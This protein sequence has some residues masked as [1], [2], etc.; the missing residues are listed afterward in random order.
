MWYVGACSYWAPPVTEYMYGQVCTVT[1]R[2]IPTRGDKK[3]G[4]SIGGKCWAHGTVNPASPC[5]ICDVVANPHGWSLNPVGVNAIPGFTGKML[6]GSVCDDGA[7][8]THTDICVRDAAYAHPVSGTPHRCKGTPYTCPKVVADRSLLNCYT[9]STCRGD[10]TCDTVVKPAGVECFNNATADACMPVWTCD[11]KLAACPTKERWTPVIVPGHARRLAVDNTTS[12]WRYPELAAALPLADEG[13]PYPSGVAVAAGNWS[14]RCGALVVDAGYYVTDAGD[15]AATCYPSRVA[16]WASTTPP[17]N[18]SVRLVAF[19]NATTGAPAPLPDGTL[20][21][22]VVRGTNIDGGRSYKCSPRFIVDASPPTLG[23]VTNLHP[24]LGTPLPG[25]PAYH[26]GTALRFTV[27][28]FA[29]PHSSWSGFLKYEYMVAA[30]PLNASLPSYWVTPVA[31]SIGQAQTATTANVLP[32][33]ATATRYVVFVRAW[34]SAALKSAWVEGASVVI[35]RTGPLRLANVTDGAYV[36]SVE[37]PLS[38]SWAGSFADPE[39]GISHYIVFWGKSRGSNDLIN[40]TRYE[41]GVTSLVVPFPFPGKWT[42]GVRY[43][44]SVRAVSRSGAYT[45]V[46]ATGQQVDDTAPYNVVLTSPLVY[47]RFDSLRLRFTFLEPETNFRGVNVS[48]GTWAGGATLASANFTGGAYKEEVELPLPGA[49]LAHR[50]TVHVCVRVGNTA[51]LWSWP[52]V[53][54]ALLID[55]AIPPAPRVYAMGPDQVDRT[56]TVPGTTGPLLIFAWDA[57]ANDLSGINRYELRVTTRGNTSTG[58]QVPFAPGPDPSPGPGPLEV[59]PWT[60]RGNDLY[61]ELAGLGLRPGWSYWP[62]VRCYTGS[63]LV[64]TTNASAVVVDVSRP[65]LDALAVGPNPRSPQRWTSSATSLT[66]SW[67]YTDPESRLRTLDYA[68]GLAASGPLAALPEAVRQFTSVVPAFVGATT[69][70]GL[71]LQNGVDYVITLRASNMAGL[72][73]VNTSEAIR[74]DFSPPVVLDVVRDGFGVSRYRDA[75]YASNGS[76]V[77]ATWEGS[78][79][80]PQSGVAGFY[81][82]TGTTPGG[83][84]VTAMAEAGLATAARGRPLKALHGR[85]VYATVVAM[86]RAG[87]NATATSDGVTY[88]L[89]PPSVGGLEVL[90]GA[91]LRPLSAGGALASSPLAPPTIVYVPSVTGLVL[92]ASGFNTSYAPLARLR[93]NV[94]AV[95]SGSVNGSNA[96]ITLVDSVVAD[97]LSTGPLQPLPLPPLVPGVPVFVAVT[98]THAGGLSST[99]KLQYRLVYDPSPP[100]LAALTVTVA[101]LSSERVLPLCTHGAGDAQSGVTEAFVVVTAAEPTAAAAAASEDQLAPTARLPVFAFVSP[102]G[103]PGLAAAAAPRCANVTVPA[104]P[105]AVPLVATLTLVNGAGLTTAATSAAFTLPGAPPAL[106]PLLVPAQAVVPTSAGG[107]NVTLQWAP[108]VDKLAPCCAY[109]LLVALDDNV[110]AATAFAVDASALPAL[111]EETVDGGGAL[112][113]YTLALPLVPAAGRLHLWLRATNGA[114]LSTTVPATR[115]VPVVPSDTAAATNVTVVLRSRAAISSGDL[116]RGHQRVLR[117]NAT[118]SVLYAVAPSA[119]RDVDFTAL[120]VRLSTSSAGGTAVPLTDWTPAP[121]TGVLVF[122]GLNLAAHQAANVTATLR[123]TSLSGQVAD[124][125]SPPSAVDVAPPSVGEAAILG[126]AALNTTTATAVNFTAAPYVNGLTGTLVVAWRGLGEADGYDDVTLALGSKP[127]WADVQPFRRLPAGCPVLVNATDGGA[128]VATCALAGLQFPLGLAKALHVT[129]RGV[130]AD[131]E[132]RYAVPAPATTTN[133]LL[134]TAPPGDFSVWNAAGRRNVLTADTDAAGVYVFTVSWEPPGGVNGSTAAELA[135]PSNPAVPSGLDRWEVAVS[136]GPSE[137]GLLTNWT[138]VDEL[139]ATAANVSLGG[140]PANGTSVFLLVAAVSR[141]G[142]RRV[143]AAPPLVLDP[144]VPEAVALIHADQLGVADRLAARWQFS[145][146]HA[147]RDLAYTVWLGAS[148]DGDELF[149]RTPVGVGVMAWEWADLALADGQIVFLHVTGCNPLG[150]CA[151]IRSPNGAQVLLAAPVRGGN[152]TLSVADLTNATDADAA[153]LAAAAP[154]VATLR[155]G[156]TLWVAFDAFTVA[157]PSALSSYVVAVG[158]GPGGGNFGVCH[159]ATGPGVVR[160]AVTLTEEPGHTTRLWATATAFSTS[161]L[162]TSF[163]TPSPLLVD[164]TEPVPFSVV[165]GERIVRPPFWQVDGAAWTPSYDLES[166]ANLTYTYALRQRLT[167]PG[168]NVSTQLVVNWTAVDPAPTA[169]GTLLSPGP[170]SFKPASLAAGLYELGVRATNGGGLVQEVWADAHPLVVDVTPPSTAAATVADGTDPSVDAAFITPRTS[171]GSFSVRSNATATAAD[172]GAAPEPVYGGGLA[173]NTTVDVWISWKGFADADSWIDFYYVGLGTS[174][175]GPN[176][177]P[178]ARTTGYSSHVFPAVPAVDGVTLYGFVVAT[179]PVGDNSSVVVSNGARVDLT[180]PAVAPWAAAARAAALSLQE[181]AAARNASRYGYVWSRSQWAVPD[182]A[183]ELAVLDAARPLMTVGVSWGSPQPSSDGAACNITTWPSEVTLAVPLVDTNATDNDAIPQSATIVAVPGVGASLYAVCDAGFYRTPLGACLPCAPS[184]Y[185]PAPGDGACEACP[186]GTLDAVAAAAELVLSGAKRLGVTPGAT[187]CGCVDAVGQL[188]DH[189]ARAC[190]CRPGYVPVADQALVLSMWRSSSTSDSN[191]TA[192]Q[193]PPLCEPLEGDLYKTAASDAA[194]D[195]RSCPV[196]TMPSDAHD[197]CLCAEGLEVFD[198]ASESCACAAG[199]FDAGVA[200][201]TTTGVA[202]RNC[203]ACPAGTAKAAVGDALAL[204]VPCP[205]G[206]THNA[207]RTGC[208]A[209]TG[210]IRG[211]VL[212][213]NGSAVACPPGSQY[214]ADVHNATGAVLSPRCEACPAGSFQPLYVVLPDVVDPAALPFR[215]GACPGLARGSYFASHVPDLHLDWSGLFTD[216][217]AGSG[218]SHYEITVGSS[219]GG[220]QVVPFTRFDG[221]GTT[222]ALLQDVDFNPGSPLFLTVVAFDEA[223]NAALFAD[224]RPVF[225]DVSPPLGGIVLD[226]DLKGFAGDGGSA[227]GDADTTEATRGASNA[228]A[229]LAAP[230]GPSDVAIDDGALAGVARRRALA[231]GR[232]VLPAG[233]GSGSAVAVVPA[234]VDVAGG[235][236]LQTYALLYAQDFET[237]C[238]YTDGGWSAYGQYGRFGCR[239]GYGNG[240]YFCPVQGSLMG[241]L[242]ANAAWDWQHAFFYYTA[243]PEGLRLTAWVLFDGGDY[244]PYTDEGELNAVN[245]ANG[246]Y[247]QLFYRSCADVGYGNSGWVFVD[248]TSPATGA[249]TQYRFTFRVR[250]AVD[251][252]A[253]SRLVFDDVKVWSI[254]SLTPTP[255]PP[256]SVT[257]T[258]AST[259]T[260][261]QTGTP[262]ASVTRTPAST[263]TPSQTGTPTP[264]NTGTGSRSR[265]ASPTQTPTGTPT[266]TRTQTSTGTPTLASRYGDARWVSV[267][268]GGTPVSL[269]Y[270]PSPP[271]GSG[272]GWWLPLPNTVASVAAG[273]TTDQLASTNASNVATRGGFSDGGGTGLHHVLAYDRVRLGFDPSSGQAYVL[274]SDVRYS[275]VLQDDGRGWPVSV[276]RSEACA[277]GGLSHGYASLDLRGTPFTLASASFSMPGGWQWY[278]FTQTLTASGQF[279]TT[280]VN[281]CC[282]NTVP[283]ASTDGDK[284]VVW[285]TQSVVLPAALA[286][287]SGTASQTSTGSQ[288][289]T[290]T[291]TGTQ[292]ATATGSQTGS[293]TATQTISPSTTATPTG[294]PSTTATSSQT[295]SSTASQTSTSTQTGTRTGTRTITS[296][297]SATASW[298]PTRSGTSS[299]TGTP[300][301]S[302]TGTASAS[303]TETPSSSQSDTPSQSQTGSASSS[304]TPTSSQTGTV[305]PTP[306]DT[307]TGSLTASSTETASS[308]GSPSQTGSASATPSGTAS[309]TRTSTQTGTG[310]RT[311]SRSGTSSTSGTRTTTGTGSASGT[312]TAT[313]SSTATRTGSR[314]GSNTLTGTRTGTRTPASTPSETPPETA[315]STA[316]ATGTSS[317]SATGSGSQTG[318]PSASSTG[319]RTGTGSPSGTSSATGSATAPASGSATGSGTR[320]ATSSL[321]DS[322]SRSGTGSASRTGTASITASGTGTRTATGSL[323]APATASG[324]R[325]VTPSAS[326]TGSMTPSLTPTSTASGTASPS[327]SASPSAG[328]SASSSR[329]GTG[330]GTGTPSSSGTGTRSPSVTPTGT[331]TPSTTVGAA[332]WPQLASASVALACEAGAPGCA[333]GLNFC[334]ATTAN[335]RRPRPWRG[336]SRRWRSSTAARAACAPTAAPSCAGATRRR[337]RRVSSAAAHPR[338]RPPPGCRSRTSRCRRRATCSP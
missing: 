168:G 265:T 154:S 131:G 46:T 307:A 271:D 44:G 250:N 278:A 335:V 163:V 191:A 97:D 68:V 184:S 115:A 300:S 59:Y 272:P 23:T 49:K 94:T 186:A 256:A 122:T 183:D 176:V 137:A 325:T 221:A 129:V 240:D 235:R 310:T 252:V 232:V 175:A 13:S 331:P 303:V 255:T 234:P 188:Y 152:I 268:A 214:A 178:L 42:I 179:N 302:E 249:W 226:G 294:T 159:P 257:R 119:A 155:K 5:D 264:S 141:A 284:P 158:D 247:T 313:G 319:S 237:C 24:D 286:T 318:T 22:A 273:T 91:R 148:P 290:R 266:P 64:N 200:N 113:S 15:G 194:D 185:K 244:P 203:T 297:R 80:D 211:A 105:V 99:A 43:Y 248:W 88:D 10:D 77:S 171:R 167:A 279:A 197:T 213:P 124:Y 66:F 9:T 7:A 262:P 199:H 40:D 8:C 25:N 217:A 208:E 75:D 304:W 333:S 65:R 134:V 89:L 295:A 204:C 296:T 100:T 170:L 227:A 120:A 306:S 280:R 263:T 60:T 114:G 282:G 287:P 109:V 117:D 28:G 12:P 187:S 277:C 121:P 336:R 323:T 162:A 135:A 79:A 93:Y 242:E 338:C 85:T 87:I 195:V 316:S 161:G 147:G 253:P 90:D 81:W 291:P 229:V 56:V 169:D 312:Q 18:A 136:S 330:S 332:T 225:I 86:N 39:S 37:A 241:E 207:S 275:R 201:A 138:T 258:P 311:A 14:V 172:G 260:P 123:V 285:L 101:A 288:T 274:V 1:E 202:A 107:L 35:D 293:T 305:K 246:A 269:W 128:P 144:T 219:V 156:D 334:R 47:T 301:Q 239:S 166:P 27:S 103:A 31:V 98:A 125:A 52:P 320:T 3:C 102:P 51:T 196:G 205:F 19:R 54:R 48:V 16:S 17:G 261:S 62:Q 317:S 140:S 63:G 322:A 281:G 160:C 222:T 337:A 164:R 53:C 224:P 108:A 38:L 30:Y 209:D 190:V 329:S 289:A 83:C 78:F 233:N 133:T 82:C 181:E 298:T 55:K 174:R 230:T 231:A 276:L 118:L 26:A 142:L 218:L 192:T 189:A 220:S 11:G 116:L 104:L 267:T 177:A 74:T 180:P 193:L 283:T 57:C 139:A 238:Y 212:T 309:N 321:T 328:A 110:T 299:Q 130:N 308:T 165:V 146:L 76:V 69:A 84:D 20:V 324:T 216:G 127:L 58:L 41:V 6:P 236:R 72:A 315:S 106:G 206:A 243:P 198:A 149:R 4:C 34:N 92:R 292:T 71:A 21:K 32:L 29:D 173:S 61:A 150:K 96:S 270:D 314:S 95:G 254:A 70:G 245:T 326:V 151:T 126:D 2:D 153:A 228:S 143:V 223:G 112:V 36:D 259:A 50:Q 182:A 111:S 251:G 157:A 132:T 73:V 45:T 33:L 215:C 145:S 210:L 327:L 67:A